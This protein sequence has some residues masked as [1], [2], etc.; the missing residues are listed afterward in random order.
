MD[1]HPRRPA[2]AEVSGQELG[3]GVVAYSPLASA[4]DRPRRLPSKKHAKTLGLVCVCVWEDASFFFFR[5]FFRVKGKP[6][7]T[8][9]LQMQKKPKLIFGHPQSVQPTSEFQRGP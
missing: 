4:W 7:A 3:I 5:S 9:V 6:E 8:V 2:A 1:H